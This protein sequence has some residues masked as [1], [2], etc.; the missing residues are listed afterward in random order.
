ML[1]GGAGCGKTAIVMGKLRTLPD[2][3]L[4]TVLNIN[5]FTNAS[6]LQKILEG[7][8]TLLNRRTWVAQLVA[9]TFHGGSDGLR[10]AS[11]TS[12]EPPSQ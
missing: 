2:D 6:S 4:N 3:Y 10:A 8:L 9:P 11:L 12:E 7:P 1:V 5:Y